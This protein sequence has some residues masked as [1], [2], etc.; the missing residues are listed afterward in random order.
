[1]NRPLCLVRA[2]AALALA[3]ALAS[4]AAAQTFTWTKAAGTTT[5]NTNNNWN[6]TTG[7]PN[8][9]TADVVFGDTGVG[10][11][12]IATSV[13]AQSLSFNNA[14]G[15]YTLTSGASQTLSGLTTV[16]VGAAVT[17]QESI[18]LGFVSSGAL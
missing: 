17:G 11:V 5:W 14:A 8:S 4:P 2:A 12:N 7:F 16:T 18:N 10:T 6:P 15:G 13:Q 3:L 9:A 1:M